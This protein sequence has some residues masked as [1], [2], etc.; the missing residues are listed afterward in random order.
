M[1]NKPRSARQP[2]RPMGTRRKSNS[3]SAVAPAEGQKGFF[4]R[5]CEA[6]GAVVATVSDEVDGVVPLME[7]EFGFR[8]Q[9]G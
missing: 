5:F 2:L 8:L 7:T 9:V 1:A 4:I 3:A 6:V